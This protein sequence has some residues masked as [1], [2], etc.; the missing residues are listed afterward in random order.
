MCFLVFVYK[1][2]INNSRNLLLLH[3]IVLR[4]IAVT[5]VVK[6]LN[7]LFSIGNFLA[8]TPSSLENRHPTFR[9]KL[10]LLF[11]FL[12]YTV[13][14]M[15]CLYQRKFLYTFLPIISKIL[16]LLTDFTLSA[17]N[18]YGVVL[19]IFKRNQW[20]ALTDKLRQVDAA[21]SER[22]YYWVFVLAHLA[23]AGCL[24]ILS[25]SWIESFKSKFLRMFVV[26][27]FQMYSLFF[28]VVLEH[29]VLKALLKRYRRQKQ[30]ML[31]NKKQIHKQ[32]L[33]KI[34]FNLLL[35]KETVN[36][37]ND[38]FGWQILFSIMY[39]VLRSLLVFA[40]SLNNGNPK[41][42]SNTISINFIANTSTMLIFWVN[43]T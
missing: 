24:T 41:I 43:N 2:L 37:F 15:Y 9:Q 40:L 20:F 8:L 13:G 19:M 5:M 26:E 27:Y 34:K 7:T 25:Y 3:K 32:I 29:T 33:K 30:L 21:D 10:Y 36:V 42:D 14:A 28:Y 39:V 11:A 35:L 38:I 1:S 12:F 22:H 4:S 18:C 17:H 31:R 6:I 23:Y 16:R